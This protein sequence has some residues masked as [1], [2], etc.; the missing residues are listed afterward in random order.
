MILKILHV[1]VNPCVCLNS[2]SGQ[3]HGSAPTC[4]YLCIRGDL[5]MDK[6]KILLVDDEP[7]F[8]E[9]I[10]KRLELNGYEVA[11]AVNGKEALEMITGRH[12][13]LPLLKN[14][15]FDA[16]L[17]D[18][19]MPEMDGLNALKAIR[20]HNKN[21]PVFMLTAHSDEE[22]FQEAN[23]LGASGFIVKTAD[24][25]KEIENITSILRLSSKFHPE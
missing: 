7:D 3:T 1:D 15:R 22:Q 19:L 10:K 16:V 9:L 25:Q 8:V 24:L 17:L 6:K 13:G 21:L 11:S 4:V 23:R 5:T 2:D 14:E 12:V 18:I 20:R